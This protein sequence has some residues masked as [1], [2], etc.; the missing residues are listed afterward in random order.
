MYTLLKKYEYT[1]FPWL[2]PFKNDQYDN[3][4]EVIGTCLLH[5]DEKYIFLCHGYSYGVY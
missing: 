4:F 2:H 3:I 5:Q 1:L